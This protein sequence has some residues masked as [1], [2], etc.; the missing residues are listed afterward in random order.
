[1]LF[2]VVL[3]FWYPKVQSQDGPE[4]PRA[5]GALDDQVQLCGGLVG[6]ETTVIPQ[7]EGVEELMEYEVIIKEVAALEGFCKFAV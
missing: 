4:L 1:M 7:W 5:M 2:I 6:A 3:E